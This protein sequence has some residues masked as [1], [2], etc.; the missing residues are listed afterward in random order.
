MRQTP[1]LGKRIEDGDRRRDAVHIAVAAVTAATRLSPGQ[2]IGLVR[3]DSMELVGPSE[4]N[5]G[6]VDPYL[7]GDIEEGQRFWMFLYP[8]TISDL[9]HIWSHP[10]FSAVASAIREKKQ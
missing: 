2:H 4:H 1:Q 3:A 8:D 7:I 9:R 5:I 6:I 10:A